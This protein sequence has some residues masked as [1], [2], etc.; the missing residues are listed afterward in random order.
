M[1]MRKHFAISILLVVLMVIPA[2]AGSGTEGPSADP[3][4]ARDS[5]AGP[6]LNFTYLNHDAAAFGSTAFRVWDDELVIFVEAFPNETACIWNPESIKRAD[7]I[8]QAPHGHSSHY[9]PDEVAC[10]ARNTG[11][12]VAGN[13]ALHNDMISRGVDS[14]KIVELNPAMGK[15]VTKTI[16]DLNVQITSYGMEHTWM[17][18]VQDNTF[19]VEMPSGVKWYHGTC[20][21]GSNTETYMANAPEL[22]GLDVMLLD[23]DL[24]KPAIYTNY[25]PE[26]V[27]KDHDYQTFQATV[28]NNKQQLVN[29]LS[30]NQTFMY[31]KPDHPPEVIGMEF[32]PFDGDMNTNFT[33]V[34]TYKYWYD[35][36]AT[37]AEL[38]LDGTAV[39]LTTTATSGYRT[40]VQYTEVMKMAPGDHPYHLEFEVD[41]RTVRVPTTGDINFHVNHIPELIDPKHDPLE[42]DTDSTYRISLTYKDPENATPVRSYLF[43][44][45]SSY[46]MKPSGILNYAKGVE[47]YYTSKLTIGDHYY[48]MVFSDGISEVR[49]PMKGETTFIVAR[50]NYAPILSLGGVDLPEGA[51]KDTFTFSVRYKDNHGDTAV[52]RLVVIDGAP[53]NMTMVG[54]DIKKGV[55]FRYS[56]RLDLGNHTFHFDF[57]DGKFDVRLPAD[58]GSDLI[59]PTVRNQ[60]PRA[61]IYSPAP[62]SEHSDRV[63]VTFNAS[64][65]F[66]GDGDPL[67]VEWISD[68][69]GKLGYGLALT[70][71]LSAGTHVITLKVDDGLGGM[72]TTNISIV[73]VHYETRLVPELAI[74]PKAPQEGEA[75]NVLF[76]LTNTGNLKGE[77]ITIILQLDG[78]TLKSEL[79]VSLLPLAYKSFTA[80]FT[81]TPGEHQLVLRT[82]SI[83]DVTLTLDV[84][85]RA[86]PVA[87]AGQDMSAKVGGALRFD[88]S[89]S[90]SSGQLIYFHWDF[91]DGSNLTGRIVDHIYMQAGTYNVTLTV[92]DDLGKIG[93]DFIKVTVEEVVVEEDPPQVE[94]DGIGPVIIIAALVVLV[95]VILAIIALLLLRKRKDVS[96]ASIGQAPQ[97]TVP[98]NNE[99]AAQG[100]PPAVQGQTSDIDFLFAP[101]QQLAPGQ[102]PAAPLPVGPTINLTQDPT[103][104][105]VAP[106]ETAQ[107]SQHMDLPPQDGVSVPGEPPKL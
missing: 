86:P 43:M 69:D 12:Y 2:T 17:S 55:E 9:D 63:P 83:E 106:T 1:D 80:S 31:T 3:P 72:D 18:G 71:L 77:N 107:A 89:G 88:A 73:V 100:Q 14:N 24:I 25:Y 82:T 97:V 40:G 8:L 7:L 35:R 98:S 81:A 68:L 41:G 103:S 50:A 78:T 51:R 34:A 53:N 61:V 22:K 65:T 38:F 52:K 44:D 92:K 37:R 101:R 96:A 67:I 30:H 59:G 104:P 95:L 105:V 26:Y 56:T 48:H 99:Q 4:L 90:S 5:R 79:L 15:K 93:Y 75:V 20:S 76:K 13:N 87:S 60:F 74:T 66:D 27:I 42:G 102:P 6:V 64:G 32:T 23:F 94:D 47:F 11:A 46:N 45:G 91:D 57:S 39:P 36:P 16:P 70:K 33:F 84:P 54:T 49:Y 29:T 28:Y 62:N 58:E 85:V 10:V 19:L 21:S